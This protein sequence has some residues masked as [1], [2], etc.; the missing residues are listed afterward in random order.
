MPKNET[1]CDTGST[2][3]CLVLPRGSAAMR[4]QIG[5]HGNPFRGSHSPTAMLEQVQERLDS[6]AQ[7][8]YILNSSCGEEMERSSLVRARKAASQQKRMRRRRNR[9]RLVKQAC[10]DTIEETI[11]STDE[12][13]P[14][15]K[16]IRVYK[17]SSPGSNIHIRFSTSCHLHIT[18]FHFN[19]STFH[20][21]IFR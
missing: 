21:I 18:D 10:S 7:D 9:V 11:S 13:P 6:M 17:G 8:M 3:S 1:P 12:A 20:S 16:R 19:N 4:N 2:D 15:R 5:S 14:Q